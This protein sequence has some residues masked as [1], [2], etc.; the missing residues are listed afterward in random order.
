M[1]LTLDHGE[2][3]GDSIELYAIPHGN[4]Q[5][6]P[7]DRDIFVRAMERNR[8]DLTVL[9]INPQNFI[10]RQRFMAHKCALKEIE[11]YDVKGLDDLNPS[12]PLTWE[13]C[14]VN[15]VTLD[16]LDG[17]SM[18]ADT[19]LK[20][21][22]STYSYN[23]LAHET[24]GGKAIME[25][26]VRSI[27]KN[28]IGRDI[29]PYNII[30]QSLYQALM[31]KQKV[32]L[33][34]M[35]DILY[36]RILANSLSL[37]ELKDMMRYLMQK[38]EELEEPISFKE[39]GE[40]FFPHIFNLPKDLYMTAILKESFQAATSMVAM[41]GAQHFVPIQ[42]YW[43]P[44]PYGINYSE[45]IRIPTRMIGE[46][47]EDLIEKHA[48][49]DSVLEKRVW[50]EDYV[51]NAFPYIEEDITSISGRDLKAMQKCF[52]FHYKKYEDFKKLGKAGQIPSYQQRLHQIMANESPQAEQ[53]LTL[54]I[55]EE[56]IKNKAIQEE[57][58][59]LPKFELKQYSRF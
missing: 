36:R 19:D 58:S 3:T 41:V 17:N 28:I 49:L 20:R 52:L 50:G 18:D 4:D 16:M 30:N 33:T 11:D 45:A 13:E 43:E 48:L 51:I 24:E 26:F 38:I 14:V 5:D 39:A 54:N 53:E 27:N 34:D 57:S 9:Q 44:V 55:L 59:S 35:P 7:K 40:L 23:G 2:G 31:G 56:T 21:G 12:T 29:S 10:S 1:N 6:N 8:P 46:R 32:L 47:D 37:T 22:I 25:K 42:Q 15:L